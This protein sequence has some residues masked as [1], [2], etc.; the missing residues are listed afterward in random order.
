[1]RHLKQIL[2]IGIVG[3]P[4]AEK[5][6]VAK[7]LSDYGIPYYTLS[8]IL[9]EELMIRGMDS[10]PTNY[11]K[12][13]LELRKKFGYNI[14]AMRSWKRIKESDIKT[15]MLIIDGIR[16]IEEVSFFKDVG[17]LL[18]LVF[19]HSSSET[20]FRRFKQKK[21]PFLRKRSQFNA[22]EKINFELGV[23]K[24]ITQADYVI[25]N[26]NYYE[27]NLKVQVNNLYKFIIKKIN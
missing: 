5:T 24:V 2:I 15:N 1:M 18:F 17:K 13:A 11:S 3:M 19:I 25:I 9:D 16:L 20:R 4:G 21:H 27:K 6:K 22:Q 23:G 10:T 26:E 8:S 7:L 14:L 12:V